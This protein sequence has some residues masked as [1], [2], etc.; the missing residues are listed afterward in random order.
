MDQSILLQDIAEPFVFPFT[1]EGYGV[2]V[3]SVN[4]T[5]FNDRSARILTIDNASFTR[6][7]HDTINIS[8]P[9]LKEAVTTVIGMND[10]KEFRISLTFS[11]TSGSRTGSYV[12]SVYKQYTHDK[13]YFYLSGLADPFQLTQTGKVFYGSTEIGTVYSDGQHAYGFREVV[14]HHMLS[15]NLI[16]GQYILK[17]YYSDGILR[18][19]DTYFVIYSSKVELDNP[20]NTHD[21]K[22]FNASN[23]AIVPAGE[24]ACATFHYPTT[25]PSFKNNVKIT[26]S[27]MDNGEIATSTRLINV[28]QGYHVF[29][30]DWMNLLPV[31]LLADSVF[32]VEISLT[33]ITAQ[34]LTIYPMRELHYRKFTFINHFNSQET[35]Y[36]PCAISSEQSTESEEAIVNDENI[37]Y[38]KETKTEYTIAAESVTPQIIPILREM[39]QSS[40]VVCGDNDTPVIITKYKLPSSDE[41]NANTAFEIGYR[42]AKIG[43]DALL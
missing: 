5:V 11:T 7:G 30:F 21:T 17:S 43:A 36:I 4:A 15:N 6:S 16:A 20:N 3:N 32:K 2:S 8:L 12:L 34:T 42:C 40:R 18:S 1:K 23:I 35:V 26:F 25:G 41:Q 37:Q 31:G 24:K 28:Y 14:K 9:G 10:R 39:C 29:A 19:T 13:G 22:L 27:Y 38:D 33:G